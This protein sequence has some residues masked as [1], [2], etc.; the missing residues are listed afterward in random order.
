MDFTSFDA[1]VESALLFLQQYGF[2]LVIIFA[3]LHPIIEG[4]LALFNLGLGIAIIGIP[5]AY[6]LIFISNLIGVVILYIL[7]QKV[8]KFSNYYLHKKKVSK[9]VLE[10][11]QST[12]KW[13]HIFV[14]GIPLIPTYPIKIGYM[15]SEPKFKDMFITLAASYVF[16]FLGNTFIYF[17]AI[18]FLDSGL[19]RVISV[20][21]L[22]LL[23]LFVY[24]GNTFM[25]KLKLAKGE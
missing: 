23:V 11:L 2:I 14:I 12:K 8:D 7:L 25:S 19:S 20:V 1:F 15:L 6:M 21:V 16:L 10:W 3:I 18:S 17:G 22:V 13:K 9:S 5:L 24:F 4:P